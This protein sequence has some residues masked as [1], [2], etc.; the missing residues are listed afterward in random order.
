M[1]EIRSTYIIHS[2]SRWTGVFLFC[3]S[4]ST[5]QNLW[6]TYSYAHQTYAGQYNISQY[7]P[8][9]FLVYSHMPNVLSMYTTFFPWQCVERRM[10]MYTFIVMSSVP[11]TYASAQRRIAFF[12]QCNRPIS[13]FVKPDSTQWYSDGD[14]VTPAICTVLSWRHLMQVKLHKMKQ[15]LKN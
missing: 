5:D 2:F 6:E 14:F 8:T 12:A 4:D 7:M 15:W 1:L 11:I 9:I 10:R 13:M 3:I